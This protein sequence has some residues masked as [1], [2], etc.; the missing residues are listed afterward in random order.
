MKALALAVVVSALAVAGCG[1]SNSQTSAPAPIDQHEVVDAAIDVMG[2]D[3]VQ[4]FCDL[5]A[6]T[7]DEAARANFTAGFEDD[8]GDPGLADS[9]YDQLVDRC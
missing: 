2:D 3:S 5:R 4:T 6:V 8:G 9:T 1:T 7:G